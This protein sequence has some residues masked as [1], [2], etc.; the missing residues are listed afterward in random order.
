MFA[1]RTTKSMIVPF[2]SLLLFFIKI[3]NLR[4]EIKIY[5][6]CSELNLESLFK[7]GSLPFGFFILYEKLKRDQRH[8]KVGSVFALQEADLGLIRGIPTSLEP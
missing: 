5:V 1:K 4:I 3:N 2:I 8:S 6:K 7:F